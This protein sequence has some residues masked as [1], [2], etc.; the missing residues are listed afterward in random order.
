MD[1][2][3]RALLPVGS[4]DTVLPGGV[5]PRCIPCQGGEQAGVPDDY[6]V[7]DSHAPGEA[8]VGH[9]HTHMVGWR[10]RPYR[11]LLVAACLDSRQPMH[12]QGESLHGPI[13]FTKR[14]CGS[15]SFQVCFRNKYI[16]YIYIYTSIYIY[17]S[18]V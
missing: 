4:C 6:R 18:Y 7:T 3:S 10:P 5:N 8:C 11:M 16:Q 12:F 2:P 9:T 15:F 17:I 14:M 1:A 13:W